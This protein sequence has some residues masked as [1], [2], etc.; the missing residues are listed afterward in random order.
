[1]PHGEQVIGAGLVFAANQSGVMAAI[2]GRSGDRVWVQPIGSTSAP[3]LVGQ[4][5]FISGTNGRVAAINAGTG[6]VFWVTQ[7]REFEREEKQRGRI[8]YAGP[9]VASNQV[10][11]ASSRGTVIALSPQTGERIGSLEL[12][13]PV[14]LEPI[15]VGDKV[16]VLTDDARLIAIR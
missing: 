2:D 16:F 8:T 6:Q 3:A 12:N 10:I 7:L 4:Y 15:S 5:I 13:D 11:V 14:Y 1:M 9:I